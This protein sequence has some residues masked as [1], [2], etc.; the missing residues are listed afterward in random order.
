MAL[1][2]DF[3]L[4]SN[5]SSIIWDMSPIV[6]AMID[7]D[8]KFLY[9]NRT[10]QSFWEYS[11]A[12]LKAK[13]WQDITHPEDIP[14]DVTMRKLLKEGKQ[15]SYTMSKRYLTKSGRVVWGSLTAYAF[16]E[17]GGK[18]ICF[19][20][21]VV[22]IEKRNN[23]NVVVYNHDARGADKDGQKTNVIGYVLKHFPSLLSLTM[24]IF[25]SIWVFSS[26]LGASRQ[27]VISMESDIRKLD[28]SFKET[29]KHLDEITR[30]LI[31]MKKEQQGKGK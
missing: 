2:D 9:V 16:N 5:L 3:F 23:D 14:A 28:E 29:K 17:T 27:K 21:Q 26:D 10:G 24:M 19:L 8:D 20:T 22:P 15:K 30:I 13:K 25:G 18:F 7:E 12:E 4:N 11:E 31:E 1:R 6:I